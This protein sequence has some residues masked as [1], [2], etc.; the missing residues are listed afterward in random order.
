MFIKRCQNKRRHIASDEVVTRI[1]VV[2]CSAADVKG[3]DTTRV[4]GCRTLRGLQT[5]NWGGSRK[6]RQPT[7]AVTWWHKFVNYGNTAPNIYFTN[8]GYII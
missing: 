4:K 7:V 3:C 5:E 6:D 2:L 8:N 1:V